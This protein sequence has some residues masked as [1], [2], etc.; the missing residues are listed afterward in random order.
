MKN[1]VL[2]Y[3]IP[4]LFVLLGL[5]FVYYPKYL[6]FNVVTVVLLVFFV[7]FKLRYKNKEW[8]YFLIFPLV[9]QFC[10]YA[11]I[12]IQ[13]NEMFVKF[14]L[15][16]GFVV[17]YYYFRI[18]IDYFLQPDRF[19]RVVFINI[20]SFGHLLSFYFLSASVFGFQSFL[21]T[22]IW[23]LIMFVILFLFFIILNIF[24]AYKINLISSIIFVLVG[25]V[26]LTEVIWSLSFLPISYYAQGLIAS[27]IFYIIIGITKY[28]LLGKINRKII[29]FY[30]TL[31]LFCIGLILFTS[32]WL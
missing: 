11:Y 19:N 24:W 1:K 27:I 2:Y 29:K 5:V 28:N 17:L 21:N 4:L 6:I 32:R 3:I 12:S 15:L 31:G 16:C 7:F 30:L 18:S 9:F 26:V 8:Y 14:L 22:S 25:C 20:V 10:L 13:I 23:Q